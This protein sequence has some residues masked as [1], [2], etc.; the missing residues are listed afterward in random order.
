MVNYLAQA[1]NQHLAPQGKFEYILGDGRDVRCREF[2]DVVVSELIGGV[3]DDENMSEILWQCTERNLRPGGRVCPQ[4][5]EVVGA[6]CYWLPEDDIKIHRTV[7][8]VKSS[9]GYFLEYNPARVKILEEPRTL[10]E[11]P[12][13]GSPNCHFSWKMK[14][15]TE[16]LRPN[17][18]AVWFRAKLAEEVWLTN[19]PNGKRTSWGLAVVPLYQEV[20]LKNCAELEVE[21]QLINSGNHTTITQCA[22]TPSRWK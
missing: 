2:V 21:F 9:R 3:G 13:R 14:I 18:F 20:L 6:A 19:N 1:I 15:F 12:G 17:G 11:I 8:E 16:T 22:S 7:D 5:V 4:R 10:F